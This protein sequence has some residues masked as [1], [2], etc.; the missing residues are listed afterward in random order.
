[1][2]VWPTT[3]GRRLYSS[4]VLT[5]TVRASLPRLVGPLVDGRPGLGAIRRQA[6][7]DPLPEA[8]RGSAG[9]SSPSVRPGAAWPPAPRL[10]RRR[11]RRRR[12]V[13][14]VGG[15]RNGPAPGGP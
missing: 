10:V 5:L 3:V 1:M 6:W 4:S 8:H 12:G 7:S 15:T 11:L 9:A 13:P 2:R 14:A